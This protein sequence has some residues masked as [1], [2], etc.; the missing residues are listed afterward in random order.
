MDRQHIVSLMIWKAKR[1]QIVTPQ[2]DDADDTDDVLHRFSYSPHWRVS[3]STGVRGSAPCNSS[4]LSWR[5]FFYRRF[6][7]LIRGTNWRDARD[8]C[9]GWFCWRLG[10]LGS[11]HDPS[12][13]AQCGI[14]QAAYECMPTRVCLLSV[15]WA[16]SAVVGK[17]D[18]KFGPRKVCF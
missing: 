8:R 6:G 15:G 10:Y 14:A 9:R 1:F 12:T 16:T 2:T 13:I 5:W 17:A 7:W 3:S 11:N 4:F 18:L